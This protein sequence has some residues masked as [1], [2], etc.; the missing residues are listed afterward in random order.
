MTT[1]A[2]GVLVLR[3]AEAKAGRT[4]RRKRILPRP[5]CP[6][7]QLLAKPGPITSENYA[8]DPIPFKC[9]R[10]YPR[11]DASSGLQQTATIATSSSY[12]DSY[13]SHPVYVQGQ[14]QRRSPY[15][16][17]Q[18][19]RRKEVAAC[20]HSTRTCAPIKSASG[21]AQEAMIKVM[22]PFKLK[23][24]RSGRCNLQCFLSC[25]VF[26]DY[27][28]INIEDREHHE[29]MWDKCRVH[30]LENIPVVF[31]EAGIHECMLGHAITTGEMDPMKDQ[32]ITGERF[33][34]FV[35]QDGN[36]ACFA[37]KPKVWKYTEAMCSSRPWCR[38]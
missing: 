1:N 12:A 4:I 38:R 6:C 20:R 21:T 28:A 18:A 36:V 23:Y 2:P 37:F 10:R 26:G 16:T 5:P 34:D 13:G 19:L 22:T 3:P 35:Q 8:A 33:P 17:Q 24:W 29:F 32:W 27:S 15:T 7:S 14:Q 25:K 31:E 9:R 11:D 30:S